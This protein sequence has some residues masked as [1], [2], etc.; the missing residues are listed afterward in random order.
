M[1]DVPD[2]RQPVPDI[3]HELLRQSVVNALD[4]LGFSFDLIDTLLSLLDTALV[5]ADQAS[6]DVTQLRA[7]VDALTARVAALEPN[8]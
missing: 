5:A 7:D 1:P 6:Q 8:A 4:D 3:G 2:I